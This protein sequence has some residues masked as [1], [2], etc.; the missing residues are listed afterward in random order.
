MIDK[1]LLVVGLLTV[2]AA[3][4]AAHSPAFRFRVSEEFGESR[5]VL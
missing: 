1:K 2:V 4:T 5:H 3:V